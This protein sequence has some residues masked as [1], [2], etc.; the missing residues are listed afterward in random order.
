MIRR[1]SQEEATT[2]DTREIFV[3]SALSVG[4][5]FKSR[6]LLSDVVCDRFGSIPLVLCAS[7]YWCFDARIRFWLFL[8][9]NEP[10]SNP[11]EG[12]SGL[13]VP[14]TGSFSPKPDQ[15]RNRLREGSSGPVEGGVPKTVHFRRKRTS[16][17]PFTG[18]DS[19]L[20]REGGGG[21]GSQKRFISVIEGSQCT[22]SSGDKDP[23]GAKILA[24]WNC[25]VSGQ[26][27]R[28]PALLQ[29]C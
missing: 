11:R 20:E 13:W 12:S 1:T 9:K 10:V 24:P 29:Q 28:A 21:G 25:F 7:A 14:K 26:A 2:N 17:K 23:C 8:I 6:C 19:G 4:L 16:F 15:F 22:K 18:G 27:I 3:R 5:R